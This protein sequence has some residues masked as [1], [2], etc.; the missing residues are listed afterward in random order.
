M[1]EKPDLQD[2]LIAPRLRDELS[3][4]PADIGRD[5]YL[6]IHEVIL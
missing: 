5:I 4:F 2:D 6:S 1:L 3:D